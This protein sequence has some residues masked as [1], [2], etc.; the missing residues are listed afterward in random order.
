MSWFTQSH[1]AKTPPGDAAFKM[2][3]ATHLNRTIAGFE[4]QG[5]IGLQP[6]KQRWI[7]LLEGELWRLTYEAICELW[8]V[9][10]SS[11]R[12]ETR[13]LLE[14]GPT[15]RMLLVTVAPCRTEQQL[16]GLLPGGSYAEFLNA[17]RKRFHE[18]DNWKR[19]EFV[20]WIFCVD[21]EISASLLYLWS[22]ESVVRLM[23]G[24]RPGQF[25]PPPPM[26]VPLEIV[27]GDSAAAML[28]NGILRLDAAAH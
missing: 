18:L 5:T 22:F 19:R 6:L 7:A 27:G 26:I 1:I 8:G 16:A 25:S 21:A 10:L 28:V 12:L 11:G 9:S 24:A 23:M 2:L 14:D 20:H 4:S 17:Q 3:C 15:G 13:P